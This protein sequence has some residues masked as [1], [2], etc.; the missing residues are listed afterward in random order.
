MSVDLAHAGNVARLRRSLLPVAAGLNLLDPN[1]PREV[2]L[3][4]ADRPSLI[5]RNRA[6]PTSRTTW[7][8]G[9]AVHAAHGG[10]RRGR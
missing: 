2:R 9:A 7:D 6:E 10:R 4:P 1:K 5:T 3:Q 8:G